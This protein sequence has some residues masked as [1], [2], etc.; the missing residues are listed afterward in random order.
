[1]NKF[2]YAAQDQ[3]VLILAGWLKMSRPCGKHRDPFPKIEL[4]G[5]YEV[6]PGKVAL[7]VDEMTQHMKLSS[8]IFKFFLNR[9]FYDF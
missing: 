4:L 3:I 5:S 9:I 7:Q 1:M 2:S 8:F 6:W